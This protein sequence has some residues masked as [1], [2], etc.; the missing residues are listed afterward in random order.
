MSKFECHQ[1]PLEKVSLD[2]I[3]LDPVSIDLFSH[4]HSFT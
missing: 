4:R 3:A 1:D 2:K